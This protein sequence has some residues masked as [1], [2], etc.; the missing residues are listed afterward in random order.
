LR[1]PV[2]PQRHPSQLPTIHI[3]SLREVHTRCHPHGKLG[4]DRDMHGKLTPP[5]TPPENPD[6]NRDAD[7]ASHA[8]AEA[9]Q[10]AAMVTACEQAPRVSAE[11]AVVTR[12]TRPQDPR[13]DDPPAGNAPKPPAPPPKPSSGGFLAN[14]LPNNE[15]DDGLPPPKT[16]DVTD[17]PIQVV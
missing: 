7:F 9:L 6:P 5:E 4:P 13:E 14:S 1:P 2:C 16:M 12:P 17:L 3:L 15:L 8:S 10:A 11:N